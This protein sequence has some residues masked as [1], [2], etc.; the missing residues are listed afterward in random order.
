MFNESY[1]YL[2]K[3]NVIALFEI[4]D[5]KTSVKSGKNDPWHRVCWGF[6]KLLASSGKANTEI[7]ARLQMFKFPKN[8]MKIFECWKLP[9]IKYPSTL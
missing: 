6:L 4:L 1:N 7:E 2:L 8:Q 5:L 9:R 3:P